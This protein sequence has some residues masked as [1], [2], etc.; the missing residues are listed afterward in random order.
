MENLQVYRAQLGQPTLKIAADL[1]RG[2]GGT[3]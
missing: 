2:G 1:H 3:D